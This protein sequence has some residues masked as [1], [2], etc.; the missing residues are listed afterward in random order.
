MNINMVSIHS[1]KHAMLQKFYI[2]ILSV[3]FHY[4]TWNNHSK[5]MLS[6]PIRN[7]K[8]TTTQI[9]TTKAHITHVTLEFYNSIHIADIFPLNSYSYTCRIQT[10]NILYI[11]WKIMHAM[12]MLWWNIV[13]H[14]RYGKRTVCYYKKWHM[15]L[16]QRFIPLKFWW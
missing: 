11:I 8:A 13:I 1:N 6:K 12:K 3:L 7:T 9:E 4:H 10:E 14:K 16:T 5:F 2:P 15:L